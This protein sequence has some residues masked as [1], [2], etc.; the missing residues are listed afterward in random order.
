MTER[1][2]TLFDVVAGAA[3]VMLAAGSLKPFYFQMLTRDRAPA[4]IALSRVAFGKMPGYENFL[5][6][7]R[8]RTAPGDTIALV[9]P[10]TEWNGYSW[11]YYRAS[12]V[13]AGRRVLP[14]L[15]PSNRAHPEN[16]AAAVYVAAWEAAPRDASL[17]VIW[18]TPGGALLRRSR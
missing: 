4:R 10:M 6:E 17:S 12:Y 2:P 3:L 16:L 9:V 14:L 11:A 7:V 15:D 13:L 5:E 8:A 1:R 18:E